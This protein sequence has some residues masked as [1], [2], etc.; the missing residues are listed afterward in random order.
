MVCKSI[1]FRQ[2]ISSTRAVKS[3]SCP[4][5]IDKNHW[6]SVVCNYNVKLSSV[7]PD[8]ILYLW[9][10]WKS[11]YFLLITLGFILF[12]SKFCY[13]YTCV[14]SSNEIIF[15]FKRDDFYK[16]LLKV[17]NDVNLL[18]ATVSNWVHMLKD[19]NLPV[20]FF[21]LSHILNYNPYAYNIHR[22]NLF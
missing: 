18:L 6:T 21:N 8:T 12:C 13:I 17:K 1:H 4:V 16:C 5:A 7:Q 15:I 11:T 19:D 20:K 10:I 3:E 2:S 9:Y 22:I 14:L